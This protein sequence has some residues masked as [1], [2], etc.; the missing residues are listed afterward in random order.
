M[1]VFNADSKH[2]YVHVGDPNDETFSN[3]FPVVG[4]VVS[5]QQ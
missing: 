1:V 4:A 5:I 3:W 2:G